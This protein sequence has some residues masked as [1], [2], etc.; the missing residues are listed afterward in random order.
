[1]SN[2]EFSLPALCGS[3]ELCFC[4]FSQTVIENGW[5][6]SCWSFSVVFAALKSSFPPLLDAVAIG[7]E[8]EFGRL[9]SQFDKLVKFG[10]QPD[11]FDWSVM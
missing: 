4:S 10:I 1:M 5:S 11:K 7:R 6:P 3:I 2:R 8:G 9:V